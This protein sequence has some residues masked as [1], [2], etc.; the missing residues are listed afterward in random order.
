MAGE[1]TPEGIVLVFALLLLVGLVYGPWQTFWTEWTR[2]RLFVARDALFDL[3]GPGMALAFDEPAYRQARHELEVLIRFV[4]QMTWPRLVAY[5]ILAGMP[6]ER[7]R[8]LDTL[9]A[10]SDVGEKTAE[11]RDRVIQDLTIAFLMRSPGLSAIL[12]IVTILVLPGIMVGFI[13]AENG[14]RLQ[15]HA[16][17]LIVADAERADRAYGAAAG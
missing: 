9:T 3:A 15:R 2:E 14:R 10:R 5:L 13:M 1:V 17:G 12:S 4:H 6:R 16:A 8:L 11:I 7:K